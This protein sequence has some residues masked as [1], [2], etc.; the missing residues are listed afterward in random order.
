VAVNK[1]Q[2]LCQSFV[3]LFQAVLTGTQKCAVS[4]GL[5]SCW[6]TTQVLYGF[7]N[8]RVRRLKHTLYFITDRLVWLIHVVT[9]RDGLRTTVTVWQ[10]AICVLEGVD[11]L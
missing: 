5:R 7:A 8:G 6:Q 9:F 2:H 3:A 1:V 10:E 4:I 11:D